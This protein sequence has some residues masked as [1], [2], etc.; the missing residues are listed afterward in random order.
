MQTGDVT[1][2]P[3]VGATVDLTGGDPVKL[4]AQVTVAIR[5]VQGPGWNAQLNAGTPNLLELL[6]SYDVGLGV[7]RTFQQG[8]SLTGGLKFTTQDNVTNTYLCLGLTV[9]LDIATDAR[10][11]IGCVEDQLAHNGAGVGSIK[12][13]LGNCTQRAGLMARSGF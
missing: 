8:T 1:I 12:L 6:R 7:T 3:K 2:T 4:L 5:P 11:G 9:P 10:H 13:R